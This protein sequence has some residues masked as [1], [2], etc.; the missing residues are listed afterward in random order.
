[1]PALL[2][3]YFDQF[4][5]FVL[6]LSR[7]SALIMTAPVFGSRG[8]PVIVRAFL[9]I[10][11]SLL[12][13]PMQSSEYV[14]DPGNLL[15]L[16]IMIG[17]EAVIGLTLG[18]GLQI[19]FTGL[20]ITGQVAGQMSGM[21]L[22][23]IFDP[24][25]NANVPLFAQLMELVTLAV[26]IILGGHRQVMAA[27]LDTFKSMPPGSAA[28]SE[29]IVET[30]IGVTTQSFILGVRAAAPVMVAVLL[31]ILILGLISRTLPQLNIM[32]VG[33]SL[34]SVIMMSALLISLGATVWI[35]QDQANETI[36]VIRDAI[37]SIPI[38]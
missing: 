12:I 8:A 2:E 30:L 33:F 13:A 27:L 38:P 28:F 7:I 11:L 9:A 26:F 32:A 17:S 31:S 10:T 20:Q 18:F 36:L 24:T 14:Q 15:N 21:S 34:N 35:F 4:L 16:M 23:D 1:M 6:V 3:Q 37:T 19:L 29:S 5:V 22:A 25:F